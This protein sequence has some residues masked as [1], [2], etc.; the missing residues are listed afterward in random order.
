[1]TLVLVRRL[2]TAGLGIGAAIALS[3]Q[4][5]KPTGWFGKRLARAMN[6]GHA[7]LTT[8]GLSKITIAPRARILDVGCGGGRTIQQLAQIAKEGR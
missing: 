3:Q 6:L 7:A 8:W 5:R 4:C 1:M 2:V